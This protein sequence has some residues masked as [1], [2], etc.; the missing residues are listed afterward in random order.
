MEKIPSYD[1]F[2]SKSGIVVNEKGEKMQYRTEKGGYQSVRLTNKDGRKKFRVHFLVANAYLPDSCGR[3]KI[4]HRDGNKSNNDILNLRWVGDKK[5]EYILVDSLPIPGFP[6]HFVTRNGKVY[7]KNGVPMSLYGAQGSGAK[8]VSLKH[9]G[10]S[11]KYYIHRLVA[12]VYIDN[13]CGYSAVKHID[14]DVANNK[15]ENLKWDER[16]KK[17]SNNIN[18]TKNT[19][20]AENL[21][22]IP[23]Y[24][25]YFVT[26]D[27]KVCDKECRVIPTLCDIKTGLEAVTFGEEI[28]LIH[29]LV[30]EQY[31]ENPRNYGHIKHIDGNISNNNLSNLRWVKMNKIKTDSRTSLPEDEEFKEIPSFP[32]YFITKE[33]EI[34]STKSGKYLSIHI[35]EG[36]YCTSMYKDNKHCE[37]FIHK[38][39]AEVYLPKEERDT[40]VN[41]KN[42]IKNDNR[43]ENL[44]WCTKSHDCLHARSIGLNPGRFRPVV[45]IGISYQEQPPKIYQSAKEASQETKI[46][47][48]SIRFSCQKG[49]T[50]RIG[51]GK[52]YDESIYKCRYLTDDNERKGNSP[53]KIEITELVPEEKRIN[54]F[55]SAKEANRE[56]SI[57]QTN[58]TR[59]CKGERECTTTPDGKIY[60][61]EYVTQD[62][63]PPII[64]EGDDEWRVIPG[65]SKYKISREGKVY[66]TYFG[67]ILDNQIKGDRKVLGLNDDEG[68][69]KMKYIKNLISLTYPD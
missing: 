46:N 23:G 30:A 50:V 54:T 13:P 8:I 65:F 20:D 40:C 38:L 57:D 56:T 44:E 7:N 37:R 35:R 59:C 34:F 31:I 16:S 19:Y 11:K 63:E 41:H 27:G 68:K 60:K 22:N 24:P 47:V 2:V 10:K 14:G 18:K 4:E 5:E 62:E 12:Q 48:G 39:I 17:E 36:Y 52:T 15:V 33:G 42:G 21:K 64:E 26:R 58:I 32:T 25:D 3:T 61:W 43:L 51:T 66:S 1:Y 55:K 49:T 53:K 67:R 69:R 29:H 28:F 45:Q 6:N 9:Q